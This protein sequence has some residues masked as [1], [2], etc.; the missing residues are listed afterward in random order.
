MHKQ[1]SFT[2]AILAQVERLSSQESREIWLY[3]MCSTTWEFHSSNITVRTA[4]STRG[5]ASQ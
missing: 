2:V 5:H 1:L 3:P 4:L